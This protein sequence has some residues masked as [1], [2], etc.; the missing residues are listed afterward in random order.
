MKTRA[1]GLF[2][3][4]LFLTPVLSEAQNYTRNVGIRGGQTSGFTY[5]QYMDEGNAYEGLLSFKKDGLQ[6]TFLK[7]F[8][9]PYLSGHIENIYLLWGYG[10]HVGTNRT[11]SWEIFSKR[12]YDL[13]SI[14][15]LCGIDGYAGIEYRIKEFPLVIGADY[16]P[17][18]DLAGAKFFSISIWDIAITLKYN[19]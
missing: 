16:K 8:V 17:F 14:T 12:F 11:S 7:E 3:L 5:R 18:F 4:I 6:I 10:A 9:Q 1:I 15:P 13:N 19:F 2:I